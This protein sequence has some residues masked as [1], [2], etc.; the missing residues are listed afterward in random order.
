MGTQRPGSDIDLAI[1]GEQL[2]FNEFLDVKIA[3]ERIGLLQEMDVVRFESI[4]N[5]EFV[6]HI[7]RV[8]IRVY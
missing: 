7:E 8:G 4:D 2:S 1:Y 6:D 5:P 3:L